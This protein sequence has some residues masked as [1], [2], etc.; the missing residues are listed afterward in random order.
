MGGRWAG[1]SPLSQ[2]FRASKFGIAYG[3]AGG[4]RRPGFC[5]HF[6]LKGK[7]AVLSRN[8]QLSRKGG[9]RVIRVGWAFTILDHHWIRT[10]HQDHYISGK[11]HQVQVGRICDEGIPR[12]HTKLPWKPFTMKSHPCHH[13]LKDVNYLH[14]ACRLLISYCE[15]YASNATYKIWLHQ[16]MITSPIACCHVSK[17]KAIGLF[18]SRAFMA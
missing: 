12:W 2:H 16:N 5:W 10:Y 7:L 6:T 11:D 3:R 17:T 14:T 18:I 8:R 4:D 13:S 9:Q 15:S 1:F